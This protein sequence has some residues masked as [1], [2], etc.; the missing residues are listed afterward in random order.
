MVEP[1]A[2]S[3]GMAMGSTKCTLCGIVL[4]KLDTIF[5]IYFASERDFFVLI[6]YIPEYLGIKGDRFISHLVIFFL[7]SFLFKF[8]YSN[9]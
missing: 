3:S 4:F 1:F 9:L 8:K 7:R 6:L 2:R 5:S